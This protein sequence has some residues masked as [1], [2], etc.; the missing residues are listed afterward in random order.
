MGEATRELQELKASL[1]KVQKEREEEQLQKQARIDIIYEISAEAGVPP[2]S[3]K[4]DWLFSAEH[5]VLGCTFWCFICTKF[6]SAS[7]FFINRSECVSRLCCAPTPL[8]SFD[9]GKE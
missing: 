6:R 1:R 2:F 5:S 7:F 8:I 4:A 9:C 3:R